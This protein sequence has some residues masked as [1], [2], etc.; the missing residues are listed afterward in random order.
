MTNYKCNKC[1][2][3]T[4]N[5]TH[6]ND[7]LNRKISC[8]INKQHKLI[9]NNNVHYCK[10]CNQYFSRKDS[11]TRHNKTYHNTG[12]EN[13]INPKIVGSNNNLTQNNIETQNNAHDIKT[14]NNIQ[15]QNNIETQNIINNNGTIIIQPIINIHPYEYNDINDLTLFEQYLSLTSKESPHSALLD[16]LNLDPNKPSYHNIY[17][18]NPD[19]N[20]IKVHNGDKWIKEIMKIALSNIID[21]K[22]ILI[23]MIFNKFRFFLNNKALY[24]IPRYYYYYGFKQH[25]QTYKNLMNYIK[26][27]IHNNRY[28]DK[29]ID[30]NIPSDRNDKIFWALSKKFDWPE[31]EELIIK[32]E[33]FNIDFNDDLDKIKKQ[34]IIIQDKYKLK[35]FFK[36]FL[37]RID[38]LI[39][40]FKNN[41][42]SDLSSN[43]DNISSSDS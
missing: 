6:F 32:M 18:G 37:K 23:K 43:D 2:Y 22:T 40:D 27:H 42:N 33:E 25:T 41:E 29:K 38:H 4:N 9:K 14:L 5:K 35:N 39:E 20:I 13:I 17:I 8:N 36:K 30:K 21:S 16:N 31:I 1:N 28:M 26:V 7:H 34:I 19:K 11:L 3:Q 12:N 10:M 15:T 24:H